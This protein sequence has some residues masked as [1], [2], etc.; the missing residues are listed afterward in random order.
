MSLQTTTTTTTTTTTHSTLSSILNEDN[1]MNS[2]FVFATEV[3][4]RKPRLKIKPLG[5]FSDKD[6]QQAA[7]NAIKKHLAELVVEKDVETMKKRVLK[8]VRVKLKKRKNRASYEGEYNTHTSTNIK[9]DHTTKR[10]AIY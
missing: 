3:A 5:V 10:E 9:R 6:F 1:S 2:T 4:K 8:I 7:R